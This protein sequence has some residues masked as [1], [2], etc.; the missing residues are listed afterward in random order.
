M[1]LGISWLRFLLYMNTISGGT[2]RDNKAGGDGGGIYAGCLHWDKDSS[3][4]VDVDFFAGL[5]VSGSAVI[6]DN[7]AGADGG[8]IWIV[9]L[10]NL[11]VAKDVIFG[12]NKA[13]SV[14]YMSD[15]DDITL[16]GEKIATL[17]RSASPSGKPLFT[18]AY[19]N[20]VRL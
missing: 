12:G 10:K 5:D 4:I 11:T 18:Y 14:Y 1:Q 16:H 19:N 9:D 2:I 17:K 6:N 13:V 3:F 8:G 7:K 20:K 15:S